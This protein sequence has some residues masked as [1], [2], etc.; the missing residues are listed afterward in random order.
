M[1]WHCLC[2]SYPPLYG[3]CPLNNLPH[4]QLGRIRQVGRR[5]LQFLQ[6]NWLRLHL[7]HHHNP[8]PNTS[9]Q[10]TVADS[11]NASEPSQNPRTGN[12]NNTLPPH[13]RPTPKP[14]PLSQNPKSGNRTFLTTQKPYSQN[15]CL[16]NPIP[17]PNPNPRASHP[18]PYLVASGTPTHGQSAASGPPQRPFAPRHHQLRPPSP[19]G[20]VA[21]ALA[22]WG[23]LLMRGGDDDGFRMLR[24]PCPSLPPRL[25]AFLCSRYGGASRDSF[26]LQLAP[27]E[28][29]STSPPYNNKVNFGFTKL[30]LLP[31]H[32]YFGPFKVERHL[33]MTV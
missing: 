28:L 19:A 16:P 13:C 23:Q 30:R 18:N 17:I 26:A 11:Q 5:I 8:F 4:C 20:G 3:F 33:F 7:C 10:R 32:S 25:R 29:V 31:L 12:N 24:H 14:E 1:S 22:D 2:P 9:P 6:R 15:P 21:H 27:C